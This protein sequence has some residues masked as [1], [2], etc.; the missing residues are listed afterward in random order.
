MAGLEGPDRDREPI[1]A[2]ELNLIKRFLRIEA[3]RCETPVKVSQ[4]IAGFTVQR[5]DVQ[6][7]EDAMADCGFRP[8]AEQLA[9]L[10]GFETWSQICLRALSAQNY[11]A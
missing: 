10:E 3:R 4:E 7:R 11:F 5:P 1:V 8:A 9:N 2:K 6:P